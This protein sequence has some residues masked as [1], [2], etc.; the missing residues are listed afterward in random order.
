MTTPVR[1]TRLLGTAVHRDEAQAFLRKP[2]DAALVER[3]VLRSLVMLC[4]DGCG[5]TLVVNL[6]PR[7][8]KAWA[9]DRR[10]GTTLY[11][12]VWRDGGCGSHFIVW[13]DAVLW[14]DRFEGGNREPEYDVSVDGRV[15]DVL[16]H[17][18]HIGAV[19]IASQLDLIVWDVSKALRRL[20]N[21][22]QARE[23]KGRLKGTYRRT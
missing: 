22:G 17:D 14:C 5:E 20:S 15:L 8:G 3:G 13:R 23:G 6:D 21:L 19:T 2:G 1:T 4:P 10:G 11:P 16:R 9:L 18:R 7:T 12:S